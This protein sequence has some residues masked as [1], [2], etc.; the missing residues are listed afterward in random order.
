LDASGGISTIRIVNAGYG[1]TLPPTITIS[2]GSTVASGN[3]IFGEKVQ[4]SFSGAVGIV[5]DWNP[6]TRTLKVSGMGTDF[7]NGDIVVGTASSARYAIKIYETY[8]LTSAYDESDEIEEESD[9]I[10]DFTE[11]NPFGEV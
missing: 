7:V 10:L 8:D 5:K 11:I 9:K 3:F 4:G 1:Y 6:T 2:A